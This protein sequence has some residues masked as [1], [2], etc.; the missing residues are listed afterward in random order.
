ML[1]TLCFATSYLLFQEGLVRTSP[2]NAEVLIQL[3]TVLMSLGALV[4]FKERY[5]RRQFAGMG[6]SVW[7]SYFSSMSNCV[8]G[9]LL[10]GTIWWV[11]VYWYCQQ[12]RGLYMLWLRNNCCKIC[13]LLL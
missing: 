12:Q 6:Y 4:I 11:V 3:S 7:D 1:A 8:L 9:S 13:P 5:T 2:A 10:Q